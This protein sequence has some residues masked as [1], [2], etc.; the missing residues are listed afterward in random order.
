MKPEPSGPAGHVVRRLETEADALDRAVYDAVASRPTPTLD[1]PI[2]WISNAA[3][4][5]RLRIVIAAD[6]PNSAVEELPDR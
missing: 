3:N 2:T 6:A 5:S 4:F 1:G